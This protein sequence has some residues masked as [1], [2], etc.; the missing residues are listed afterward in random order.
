LVLA[1]Q[2]GEILNIVALLNISKNLVLDFA[3]KNLVWSFTKGLNM[4][5]GKVK[6]S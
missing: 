3:E 5:V 4:R 1:Y 2:A 6:V